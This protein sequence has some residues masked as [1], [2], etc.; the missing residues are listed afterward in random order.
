VPNILYETR[1]VED[2]FVIEFAQPHRVLSTSY[3]NG[4]IETL[5]YVVNHQSVKPND[6]TGLD[7]IIAMGR[8]QYH[9]LYLDSL[10]IAPQRAALI[11]TAANMDTIAHH[12]LSFSS[13]RQ[14]AGHINK[15]R[16]LIVD[17]WVSAGACRNALRAGDPAKWYQAR[18]G[19]KQID[20]GGTINSIILINYPVTSG[21][22]GK[23]LMVATEAKSSVLQDLK[24]P[25]RQGDGVA[26][27]TGTDQIA[28]AAPVRESTDDFLLDSASGHLKLG[29]LIGKTIREATLQALINQGQVIYADGQARFQ[30]DQ[31]L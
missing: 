4:G 28:I 5:D 7:E 6:F 21:V 26:T 9:A 27:G 14:Q 22:L 30:S 19:N 3:V 8:D 12:Q 23:A 18:E 31:K 16:P 11:G 29:E 25:S 2:A 15:N 17:V 24:V 20:Y 10:D 13:E 1:R